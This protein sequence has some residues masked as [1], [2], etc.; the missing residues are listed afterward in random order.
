MEDDRVTRGHQG[1]LVPSEYP[2]SQGPRV[3]WERKDRLGRLAGLE[4]EDP[5]DRLVLLGLME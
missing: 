1:M 4:R 3:A 5:Q 2:A